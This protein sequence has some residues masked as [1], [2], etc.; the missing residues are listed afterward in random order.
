MHNYRQRNGGE[1]PS[2]GKRIPPAPV[3][4]GILI[5]N[6]TLQPIAADVGAIAILGGSAADTDSSR[7]V[8][9]IPSE[10]SAFVE[11]FKAGEAAARSMHVRIGTGTY[12]CRAYLMKRPESGISA[13]PVLVVHL[14][15]SSYPQ[16]AIQRVGKEY[17][18][19][20]REQEAL[21][22][23][24]MGLTS[25][26]L[27][28]RMNISPN[29]VKTFVRAIMIKMGVTTRTG[30]LSKLLEYNDLTSA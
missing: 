25:K 6:L 3:E 2:R 4:G 14:Q 15:L 9:R 30:I 28:E 20:D 19:T 24:S 26:E 18:L 1:G 5:T 11:S 21:L 8:I 13:E 23:I 27:A 7:A 29:T 17:H 12:H 22:G 10:F 16:S